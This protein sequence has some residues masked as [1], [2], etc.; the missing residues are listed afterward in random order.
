M[1]REPEHSKAW[2]AK[3]TLSC[4]PFCTEPGVLGISLLTFLSDIF[5]TV[6]R[7]SQN[8]GPHGVQ[9]IMGNRRKLN[10]KLVIGGCRIPWS[11]R[12]RHL[13]PTCWEQTFRTGGS[14]TKLRAEEREA[15]RW[16]WIDRR[17]ECLKCMEQQVQ[18]SRCKGETWWMNRKINLVGFHAIHCHMPIMQWFPL[19]WLARSCLDMFETQLAEDR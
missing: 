6:L 1:C 9:V 14:T 4:H 15:G 11:P 16:N 5:W 19:M 7:D 10:Y 8:P 2:K 17:L 13:F 18:R 12:Q 3:P